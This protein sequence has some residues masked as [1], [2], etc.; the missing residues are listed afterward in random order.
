MLTLF[1]SNRFEVLLEA[2]MA[3]ESA[4]RTG[5]FAPVEIIVPSAAV[6][7]RV[8]LDWA[9]RHGVCANVRCCYLAEWL[10]QQIGRVM[11]VPDRSPLAPDALAWQLYA[12]L[13]DEAASPRA[14]LPADGRLNSYLAH[15]DAGQRFRLARRLARVFDHYQTYRTDWLAA[16]RSGRSIF[17]R[18]PWATPNDAQRDDERWQAA[19]WRA[20]PAADA[21]ASERFLA[22]DPAA[23]SVLA[24]R[25]VAVLALPT[26]A[27][28]H[29][30]LLNQLSSVVDIGVYALNPCREF[31]FDVVGD[32]TALR[33]ALAA[34]V[35]PDVGATTAALHGGEAG[36]HGGEAHYLAGEGSGEEQ[37]DEDD[38]EDG[39]GEE[40]QERKPG[41][42]R[43]EAR[44]DWEDSDR[45]RDR[46]SE[47]DF[48][49]GG[50]HQVGA[51]GM[52]DAHL[53]LGQ[54]LLAEWG[55]QSRALLS[56]LFDLTEGR[57]DA[58][59]EVF[60][61]NPEP[62]LLASVQNA[63]LSLT[64][65]PVPDS[66]PE[67]AA[68]IEVHV[69]H[70]LS[71]Q[72][73]VLHDRLLAWFDADPDLAPHDVLVTFP[74]LTAAAPLV[75]AVFGTMPDERRI[76]YRITG[77]P[78]SRVNRVARL[79]LSWLEMTENPPGLAEMIEWLRVDA[80]AHAY[81]IEADDVDAIQRALLAAGARAAFDDAP[82]GAG[83]GHS[84]DDAVMRLV[85]GYAMPDDGAPQADWLPVAS[86]AAQQWLGGL[87]EACD[88]LGRLRASLKTTRSAADWQA[89]LDW[90][91]ARFFVSEPASSDDLHALVE[92]SGLVFET[93]RSGAGTS[94][95]HTVLSV[96]VVRQAL[97]ATLDESA[98]GGVPGGG[99][100]FAALPS[101]RL[102][103][104]RVVCLLGMD[105]GALPS[106]LRAEEF[107]LI[108][109]FGRRGDRQRRDDERNLFLDLLLAS[110]H[111]LF[112]AYTGRSIRDNAVLPPS[113][114]VDELLDY[115]AQALAGEGADASDV[116]RE[117]EGLITVHPLQ[118]FAE[119]YL[120][121]D[122]PVPT[123]DV[124]RAEIGR[125]LRQ[126]I[127]LS[128]GPAE[129]DATARPRHDHHGD[130]GDHGDRADDG[131][132]ERGRRHAGALF[133]A[134]LPPLRQDAVTMEA[135]SRFWRY[136][137]ATL[138]RERLGVVFDEAAAMPPPYE[139]F[140]ADFA[141]CDAL[142]Q[143]VLPALLDEGGRAGDRASDGA[144]D[145]RDGER[146][147]R[148]ARALA[149][150]S[151]EL[152]GGATGAVV[153]E[154]EFGALSSLASR[155]A[156]ATRDGQ[157]QLRFILSVTP[158]W[159]AGLD[160]AL[161][162]SRTLPADALA[163]LTLTGALDGVTRSGRIA[164][165]FSRPHPRVLLAVWLEHL[166]L[167]ALDDDTLHAA[168]PDLAPATL[169]DA[170]LARD[171]T[172]PTPR[173]GFAAQEVHE[174][175]HGQQV[176]TVPAVRT[177]RT[178]RETRWL[179]NG[180]GF[181]FAPVDD[182]LGLLGELAAL[183]RLGLSW[184]LPFFP[185]SAYAHAT[186]G[187][188]AAVS[189]FDGGGL[190]EGERD[191]AAVRMACGAGVSLTSTFEW[192]SDWLYEP[193][194]AHLRAADGLES[195]AQGG[196][197]SG[198]ALA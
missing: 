79:F 6:A 7:R 32:R 88:D 93:L 51:L 118:P 129:P 161:W 2:L 70:S 113:G 101:L 21:P 66:E 154:R 160:A 36:L 170:R 130:R 142:A 148:V 68:G 30:A 37:H 11:P 125:R 151:P 58:Q 12:L 181:T 167:N 75:D 110:R 60:L 153:R 42:E 117:R 171:E 132:S 81:G 86:G 97:A 159:P 53:E 18:M 122:A 174:A 197:L 196:A 195:D 162:P 121:P 177:V 40:D 4:A 127:G 141:A 165:R 62:T 184:P 147:R 143:R 144:G 179:G 138:L 180:S 91:L 136:P 31:W 41:S 114:L 49:D 183:Y 198:E 120:A 13:G 156:S 186:R 50:G 96:D 77:L 44:H 5:P 175:Q 67:A 87:S 76:P 33:M 128:F 14:E 145:T 158:R 133:D 9:T 54:P 89:L 85:L 61:E 99:V 164:W 29:V 64:P 155:V 163:P 182:A 26:M 72:L 173:D 82:A 47:I 16:W 74:D 90:A 1:Q 192:L 95:D 92:A 103:P 10:W 111:R 169:S 115:C 3:T 56:T 135:F 20:V 166:V 126:V 55:R 194:L 190:A 168:L 98:R 109:A 100:T 131:A 25:R 187:P 116:A 112:V 22:L 45:D 124:D 188:A 193:L 137:Q 24:D 73:E 38:G 69:C 172:A 23:L 123:Y 106:L 104:Y 105:D 52:A 108:A 149:E 19:L 27:P 189:A 140:V 71:R 176:R 59:A 119:A 150:A 146:Q 78:P 139:P 15:A 28:L 80:F 83:P 178:V 46:D 185:K 43:D 191:D 65:V 102:L 152:P 157:A 94:A 57:V 63:I 48:D 84:L 35:M 17:E 134:P 8:E 34:G 107:D 39:Q